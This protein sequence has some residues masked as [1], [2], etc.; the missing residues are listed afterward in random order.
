MAKSFNS[1]N[2]K[3]SAKKLKAPGKLNLFFKKNKLTVLLSSVGVGAV[4]L[5]TAIVIVTIQLVNSEIPYNIRF[6]N[7]IEVPQYMGI[8]VK[9][10]DLNKEIE[11]RKQALLLKYAEYK[12][13]SKGEAEVA[14]GY[15]VTV[16]AT[17]YLLKTDGTREETAM[18]SGSLKDYAITDIGNHYTESGSAFS[19]E[20]Q[21]AIIGKTFV[22]DDDGN[23]KEPEKIVTT[24]VY[25][26][27]HSDATLRSRSAEFDITVKKVEKTE[28]PKYTNTFVMLKTGYKD[29]QT[30]EAALEK[31]VRYNLVWNTVVSSVK[32]KKFPEDKV[33]EYRT[34][35]AEPYNEYMEEN[36]LS[37][38]Q[39]LK[40]LEIDQETYFKEM[41]AYA[42]GL[43]REEM[44][45]YYIARTEDIS[46]SKAEYKT[47]G[48][49]LA[50][51]NGYSSLSEF[52]SAVSEETVERSV[53]WQKVKTILVSEAK[54]E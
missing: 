44:I 50:L 13:M 28:L 35:F 2:K 32:V 17:G 48:R 51:E 15:K 41:D 5:I 26:A 38:E 14:K 16:D 37:F 46:I 1:Q 20:I 4:A 19:S 52:E 33:T 3:A 42:Y 49:E 29:K 24:V 40:K 43:V 22:F 31:E 18:K 36:K 54:F 10:E 53:L 39:M 8:T 6:K 47:I 12:P 23:I 45:L 30:Y 27:D 21:N 11:R 7:Y 9:N 34:A 25:P